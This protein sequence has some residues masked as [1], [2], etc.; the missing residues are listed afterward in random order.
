MLAQGHLIFL[1][2][3]EFACWLTIRLY[4]HLRLVHLSLH[5]VAET[6]VKENHSF[7]TRKTF[8]YST[9]LTHAYHRSSLWLSGFT[10]FIHSICPN[11]M[12]H[13]IIHMF[14]VNMEELD[15]QMSQG[16]WWEAFDDK[17][18]CDW[19]ELEEKWYSYM[20]LNCCL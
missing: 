9:P 15:T 2:V 19:K 18:S 11:I 20:L 8:C 10:H 1:F 14:M 12:V 5:A 6:K 16:L 7:W 17:G 4:T 3:F 13:I